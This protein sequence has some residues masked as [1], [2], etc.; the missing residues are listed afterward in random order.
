MKQKRSD[1]YANFEN[2]ASKLVGVP[3]SVV[4]AKLEEEK[5]AKKN[6]KREKAKRNDDRN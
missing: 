3:H 2:L 4:K 6:R 5:E 1:E